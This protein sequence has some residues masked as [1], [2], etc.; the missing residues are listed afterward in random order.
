M[1]AKDRFE[2][3]FDVR[4]GSNVRGPLHDLDFGVALE[5]AHFMN[6]RGGIDDRL[7]RLERLPISLAHQGKL[8]N[9]L[10]IKLGTPVT[11]RI[12]KNRWPVEN[13]R[14]LFIKFGNGKSLV[15]IVV[16]HSTFDAGTITVP[17]FLFGIARAH[18]QSE[19]FFL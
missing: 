17:D 1:T 7:R 12:I 11:E 6:D 9:D 10:S 4:L 15:G 8:T 3:R 13:L 14:Q 5:D 19:I 18:E 2:Q 16:A